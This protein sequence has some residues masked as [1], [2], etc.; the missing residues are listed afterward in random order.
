MEINEEI[1]KIGLTFMYPMFVVLIIIEYLSAR[2]L[3]DVKETLSGF[4]MAI[5]ATIMRLST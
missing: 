5:G 2:E 3:F 4:V 1:V